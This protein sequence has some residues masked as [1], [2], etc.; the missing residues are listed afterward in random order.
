MPDTYTYTEADVA[1]YLDREAIRDILFRYAHGI[2]RCDPDVLREVYWPEA[3]DDHGDFKGSRDEF[4]EW[5]IPQLRNGMSTTQ[6]LMGNILI[7]VDGNTAQV[8]TCFQAYHRWGKYDAVGSEDFVIGGRYLDHMEKRGK[9]WRILTRVVAF[10]Y[11]REYP[12]TGNWR[13][14]KYVNDDRTIGARKPDDYTSK[15]FGDSLVRAPF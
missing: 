13:K 12:D 4:V 5:V 1:Q 15:M 6:H 3:T 10:D 9:E 7:R 14:A 8:E 2:D 11:F